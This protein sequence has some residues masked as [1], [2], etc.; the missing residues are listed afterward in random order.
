MFNIFVLTPVAPG[1]AQSPHPAF[2]ETNSFNKKVIGD[3]RQQV[4]NYQ[5]GVSVRVTHRAI[6][7]LNHFGGRQSNS[8]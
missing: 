1:P 7:I 4:L 3:E 8:N 6:L 2:T 5:M